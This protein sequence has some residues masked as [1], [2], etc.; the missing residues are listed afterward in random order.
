MEKIESNITFCTFGLES[1]SEIMKIFIGEQEKAVKDLKK[2]FEQ[3]FNE[4]DPAENEEDWK[5][6]IVKKLKKLEEFKFTDITDNIDDIFIKDDILKKYANLSFSVTTGEKTQTTSGSNWMDLLNRSKM[7][8]NAIR[9]KFECTSLRR[10]IIFVIREHSVIVGTYDN[11]YEI[12][13]IDSEW[14][15]NVAELFD[16]II[17]KCCN[18]RNNWYNMSFFLELIFSIILAGSIFTFLKICMIVLDQNSFIPITSDIIIF[19][20]GSLLYI[21][22]W[23]FLAIPITTRLSEYMTELY[24]SVEIFINEERV[25]KRKNMYYTFIIIIIPYVL[26]LFCELLK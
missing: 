1:I 15:N 12:S 5:K 10:E 19:L 6:D 9:I 7:S 16:I 22:I 11:R 4:N 24:P 13:G 25:K 26:Y 8:A 23:L 20:L 3:Y 21:F 18:K 14:V 2:F 17:K